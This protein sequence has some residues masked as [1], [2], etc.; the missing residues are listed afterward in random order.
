MIRNRFLAG[1]LLC[2]MLLLTGI[3]SR[4]AVAIDQQASYTPAEYNAYIAATKTADPQQRISQLNDFAAK[5]PSST[6]LPYVY[7]SEYQTY[8]QLKDFPR[9]IA[10][11][12]KLLALG[13]K[14]ET[15]MRLSAFIGRATAFY[16]GWSS[17]D[18]SMTTSDQLTAARAAATDGQKAIDAWQKP[19][20]MADDKFAAQKK[21]ATILFSTV[22]GV[23]ASALKDYAGAAQ[24]FKAALAQ[25]PN[26]AVSDYRLGVAYL[27]QTPPAYPDGFWA[28]ARAIAL[29]VPDDAKVR[30][31]LRKEIANYE[32]PQ[33]DSIVDDQ[34]KSL[35][36]LAS[37][38]PD[39]PATFT[40]PSVDDL[41]KTRQTLGSVPAIIAGLQAGGDKA[42]ATWVAA[43]GLQFPQIPAKVIGV[44]P[45]TDAVQLALA[46]ADTDDAIQAATIANLDVKVEGQPDASRLQKDDELIFGATL[47]S[48]DPT[49]LMLHFD[50]G[51][52]DPQYIPEAGKH[53]TKQLHK[54]PS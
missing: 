37:K 28:L 10:Y 24:A 19:A 47:E 23:T 43:C 22:A 17:N 11:I 18:K 52:V 13:D 40:I 32:Q 21:S 25:D 48:Y 39:R 5:F 6:L 33:C 45:G 54:K 7:Q 31:Y 51:K 46:T 8:G 20:D 4:Q 35:L 26:D 1:A 38:S 36:D 27:E 12:D 41:N 53:S 3:F 34:M 16:L 42:T 9:A 2:A 49:P 15:T 30:D 14:V 29:K 44:T 50:K